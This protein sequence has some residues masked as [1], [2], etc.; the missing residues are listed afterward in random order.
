MG[1]ESGSI[2]FATAVG[3]FEGVINLILLT[4]ANFVSRK[5]ANTSLW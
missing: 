2:N 1:I 5:V 4:I 3:M